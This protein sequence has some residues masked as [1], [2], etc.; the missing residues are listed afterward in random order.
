[1]LHEIEGLKS[2]TLHEME[3]DD[4]LPETEG[5]HSVMLQKAEGDKDTG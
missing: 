1:M 4:G 3:G 5:L 2:V